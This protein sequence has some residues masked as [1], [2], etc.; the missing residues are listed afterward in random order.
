MANLTDT[1]KKLI[2]A[3]IMMFFA[4]IAG[5]LVFYW[6]D[7]EG[8]FRF[9]LGLFLGSAC[10]CIR[11]ASMDTSVR[12]TVES[13]NTKVVVVA[14]ILRYF[15][16]AAVLAVAFIFDIFNHWA[17]VAGILSLPLAAYIVPIVSKLD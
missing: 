3:V 5:S 11:V 9:A 6:G 8:F 10:S 13:G 4:G 7:V 15:L 1:A 14:Y 16:T 17:T 12:N 2:V